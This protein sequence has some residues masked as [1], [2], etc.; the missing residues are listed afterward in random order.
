MLVGS[1]GVGRTK[2]VA[3]DTGTSTAEAIASAAA[4]F[5]ILEAE[6]GGACLLYVCGCRDE[7]GGFA[8]EPNHFRTCFLGNA[9]HAKVR[10]RR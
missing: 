9:F 8:A 10:A 1:G 2:P 3:G 7:G 4:A 6:D 5:L